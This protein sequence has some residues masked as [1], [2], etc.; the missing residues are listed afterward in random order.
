M[1]YIVI[2]AALALVSYKYREKITAQ[3]R[4]KPEIKQ[5]SNVAKVLENATPQEE[6][7]KPQEAAPV[8]KELKPPSDQMLKRFKR[9]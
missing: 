7:P 2:L 8:T 1:V 4:H 5:E 9:P 3:F 6:S